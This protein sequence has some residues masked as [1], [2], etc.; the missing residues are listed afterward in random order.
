MSP[1]VESKLVVIY[2]WVLCFIEHIVICQGEN[3]NVI[4]CD[5]VK[6]YIG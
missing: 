5:I 6:L 4:T 2:L 3:K 1:S